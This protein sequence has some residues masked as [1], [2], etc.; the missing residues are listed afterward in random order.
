MSQPSHSGMQGWQA[1][2]F[3]VTDSGQ[4]M[5]LQAFTEQSLDFQQKII[6]RSGLGDE[7]YLPDGGPRGLPA[8]P[9]ASSAFTMARMLPLFVQWP[10]LERAAGLGRVQ[11]M[12]LSNPLDRAFAK[13]VLFFRGKQGPVRTLVCVLQ[14][15][16]VLC[17][18]GRGAGGPVGGF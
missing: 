14:E 3:S 8:S 6:D 4:W 7:T 16:E 15:T 5:T 2:I 10:A 12:L 9:L 17:P 11:N 18:T 13:T 1:I